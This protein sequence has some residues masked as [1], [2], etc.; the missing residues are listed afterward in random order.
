M[1]STDIVQIAESNH[2]ATNT[3]LP[4]MK[5]HQKKD[6]A[7]I[8]MWKIHLALLRCVT[9]MSTVSLPH[10]HPI[11]FPTLFRVSCRC[12]GISL[13][14]KPQGPHCKH[15]IHSSRGLIVVADNAMVCTLSGHVS[16]FLTQVK[17]RRTL[18][19]HHMCRMET[20]S[21]RRPRTNPHV[22]HTCQRNGRRESSRSSKLNELVSQSKKQSEELT[23]EKLMG[24]HGFS[25]IHSPGT[26]GCTLGRNAS[27]CQFLGNLDVT[28][29]KVF[30]HPMVGLAMCKFPC[31]RPRKVA[32]N[33]CLLSRSGDESNDALKQSALP[34]KTRKF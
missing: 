1:H 9:C 34:M 2:R 32:I 8:P 18:M 20:Q 25:L 13:L 14:L 29:N 30:A 26:H 17:A 12:N 22:G 33:V 11:P 5:L 27:R 6:S 3:V 4:C 23:K 19:P 16:P 24:K 28:K 7:S 10:Y 15:I 21:S 31:E